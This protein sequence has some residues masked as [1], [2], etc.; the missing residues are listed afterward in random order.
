MSTTAGRPRHSLSRTAHIARRW[1]V[2]VLAIG[3]LAIAALYLPFGTWWN[4]IELRLETFDRVEGLAAFCAVATAGMLLLAP[5]WV[6]QVAAGA[7][8]GFGWGVAAAALSSMGAA[9]AAFLVSR[10]LLRG[11]V[12]NWVRSRNKFI[13]FDKA[14]AR[15]GWKVVALMRLSPLFSSALKSYFFGLTRVDL[16]TYAS[17][18]L[19]G[20]LPGLL[21]KVY[22]GSAGRA[23][24]KGGA[25][26][27]SLLAAG[28]LATI[29][30]GL[31]V[32][33]LT[34]IR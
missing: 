21:L 9:V 32:R 22:M 1:L 34:R 6:F 29:A 33:R 26:E 10:H 30:L 5:A 8:F 31:V 23:A 14:V 3:A 27:W 18:S 13:A 24:L 12:E 2:P 4:E 19:A 7:V 16:P 11:R 25:L 28:I 17:A 15:D 20:M